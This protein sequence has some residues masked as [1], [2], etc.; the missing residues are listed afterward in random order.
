[1]FSHQQEIP[2]DCL[3]SIAKNFGLSVDDMIYYG[4]RDGL[5]NEVSIGDKATLEQLHLINEL[6]A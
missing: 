2:V 3:I 6:E 5:P 4:K 1:M